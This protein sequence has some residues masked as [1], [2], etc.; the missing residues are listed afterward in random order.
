[1]LF[2]VKLHSSVF[3]VSSV[4]NIPPAFSAS[5]RELALAFILYQRG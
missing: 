5:L 3:S 4:I 1:M 2:M